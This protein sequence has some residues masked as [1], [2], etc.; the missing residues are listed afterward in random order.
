MSLAAEHAPPAPPAASTTASGAWATRPLQYLTAAEGA[1]FAALVA[2]DGSPLWR[3]IRVLAVVA[4]TGAAWL[5][6]PRLRMVARGG[7]GRFPRT[8][9]AAARRA[10]GLSFL[11]KAGVTVPTVAGLLAMVAVGLLG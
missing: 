7:L 8:A 5:A 3:V 6:Y 9:G 1:G 11:S 10:I 2:Y 4:I